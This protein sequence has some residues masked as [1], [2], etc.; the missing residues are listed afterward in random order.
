MMEY[1][2]SQYSYT[3]LIQENKET[4]RVYG[5]LNRFRSMVKGQHCWIA[6]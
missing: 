6:K 3:F 1:E 5:K 2:I 4:G